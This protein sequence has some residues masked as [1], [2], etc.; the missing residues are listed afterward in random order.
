MNRAFSHNALNNA[1]CTELRDAWLRFCYSD[2]RVAVLVSAEDA[3]SASAP[4][5]A[6]RSVVAAT[7]ISLDRDQRNFIHETVGEDEI[8]F[9]RH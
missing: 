8:A 7:S 6:S 2:D 3:I 9:T 5:F 4:T 1:R